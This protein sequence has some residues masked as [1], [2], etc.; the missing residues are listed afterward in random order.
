MAVALRLN[1]VTRRYRLA[2]DNYVDA[3]RGVTLE[4]ES[5]DM[6]AIMGPS[7]SG[8]STLM[9]VAG[10][11]DRPDSGGVWLEEARV[12]TLTDRKLAALRS[13][14]VGFVFQGFNLLSTL[15]AAENVALAG[16]Y[17]GKS[18]RE[19]MRRATELLG[20]FG[21]ADRVSH[22]PSELSGGEQQRVAIARALM[23]DPCVLMADE[24]TGNLDS[25][26]SAE[27]MAELTRLNREEGMT[28]LLVTHDPNVAGTC[29]TRVNMRDGLIAE[30]EAEPEY[31]I[32]L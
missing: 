21:L 12:D 13:S 15:S 11:L 27:I 26:T 14:Q 2:S 17:A 7:G 30:A 29:R 28:L 31:E 24:P 9:H 19:A 22:K 1:G 8:K 3:L 16:E 6:V 5:G 10:G 4:V 25:N 18:R 20:L 23:N 32:V